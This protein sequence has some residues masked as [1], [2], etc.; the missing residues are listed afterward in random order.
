ML[1]PEPQSVPAL[2][3]PM[4]ADAFLESLTNGGEAAL[5]HAAEAPDGFDLGI[6]PLEGRAP[7]DVL[8][9]TAA[10]DHWLAM[11]AATGGWTRPLHADGSAGPRT[12]RCQVVVLVHRN[13]E[14]VSR[15]RRGDEILTE[16]PEF[17]VTLD[18]LQRAL[19]LPTAPPQ[20]PTGY[21]FAATWL[22]N[23]VGR[24]AERRRS[25]SWPQACSLHPA[26][27]M[28]EGDGQKVAVD[29]LPA[30]ALALQRVCDWE[31]LRWLV[32]EGRY[33]ERN[34]T[35]ADAA[36][37]DTGSFSRWVLS[38]R[39]PVAVLLQEMRRVSSPSTGR[40]CAQVLRQLD[41][42]SAP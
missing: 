24:T 37:F 42:D 7:A 20:V 41:I 21:L 2:P 22:E 18:A 11:G 13:G 30:A 3:L 26:V 16:P 17:G 40:R 12:G 23:I 27:Q 14:V 8:L 9:G 33:R 29:D 31:R 6:L 35:G 4:L 25:L 1:Q 34:L 36:W 10:P 5:V 15:I 19:G 32:V 39:A 38:D 28:L